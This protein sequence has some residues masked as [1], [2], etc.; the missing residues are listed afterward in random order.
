MIPMGLSSRGYGGHI[1]W[2]S[3]LWMFPPMLMLN[4]GIAGSMMEYRFD[5]LDKAIGTD[6][7][8]QIKSILTGMK[9]ADVVEVVRCRECRWYNA[10][11]NDSESWSD[12]TLRYGKHFNVGP[13]DF[14]SYGQRK[15][16]TVL[17]KSD[18]KDESLE[19]G[20]D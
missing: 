2:D 16:E 11:A 8:F 7:Y 19:A 6:A 20:H 3:E 12:C 1:F 9:A 13:D 14:C 18:A 15:I 10:G 4:S 5:R 17:P